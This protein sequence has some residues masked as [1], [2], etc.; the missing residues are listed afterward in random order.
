MAELAEFMDTRHAEVGKLI[1]DKKE[2]TPDVRSALDKALAEFRDV[3]QV[4]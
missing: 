1:L 2:L 3:F 4:Q